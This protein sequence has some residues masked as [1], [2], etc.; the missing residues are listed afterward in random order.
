MLLQIVSLV[1]LAIASLS[2]IQNPGMHKKVESNQLASKNWDNV[3][4]RHV[5]KEKMEASSDTARIGY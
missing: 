3:K 4:L 5:S 1:T 2:P